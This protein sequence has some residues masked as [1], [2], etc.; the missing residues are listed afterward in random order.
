MLRRATAVL[1]GLVAAGILATGTAAAAPVDHRRG[2]HHH[3]HHHHRNH[4]TPREREGLRFAGRVL[5]LLFGGPSRQ[6]HRY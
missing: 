5:D 2:H 6:L 3:H 1:A 4:L